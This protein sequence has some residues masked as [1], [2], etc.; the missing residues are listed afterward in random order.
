[1]IRYM[2]KNGRIGYNPWSLRQTGVYQKTDLQTGHSTWV[3]LQP[4]QSFVARLRDH[5]G[6]RSTSQDDSHSFQRQMHG[7]FMS[8]A[9][10]NMGHFIEDLQS[11]IMKLNYKACFSTLETAKEHDF[12]VTFSDLQ[13]VQH[14]KQ[15]LRRTSGML[16]SYASIIGSF[17][18][19][20]REHRSPR[21]EHCERSVCLESDIFGSQIEV[22]SRR[23][24]MA[25]TYGKGTHKLLSKI[26][27]FRHDEVLVRTATTM[28]ANLDVLKRI[29][30]ING[31]ESRNLSQI[32]KQGQKD[33][34]TVKSLTTIATMY[35]PASLVA[36]L[37]SSSL[38]QF[39]YQTTAM[40]GKGHFVI[41]QEF[42]L[43]VLVTALLT[44]VTL[45]LVA[46]LQKRWRQSECASTTV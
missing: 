26:L 34:E 42:W 19:H 45:G 36:T 46:L 12:S 32:S 30:F 7:M 40:N 41:A 44:L 20:T 37:F 38:I 13:Q 27:Q 5:L 31:E 8:L 18:K 4:P 43:Y 25:L 28:E 3:L 21:S 23:L 11:S 14:F 29:S 24:D 9:L 6:H 35:L 1:M 33:S 39:Q 17:G 22:Y 2:E 10:N 15:R 16:Q